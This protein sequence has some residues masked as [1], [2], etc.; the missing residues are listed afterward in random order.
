MSRRPHPLARELARLFA[1]GVV[2]AAIQP[3]HWQV[4]TDE[5]RPPVYMGNDRPEAARVARLVGGK[6]EACP[7]RLEPWHCIEYVER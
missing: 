3:V 6:V 7:G 5:G 4:Y 2:A 1:P